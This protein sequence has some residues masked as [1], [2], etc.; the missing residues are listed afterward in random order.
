MASKDYFITN[1]KKI[2]IKKLKD[3]FSKVIIQDVRIDWKGYRIE[4]LNQKEFYKN[5][6]EA[7]N[8]LD[9]YLDFLLN[10]FETPENQKDIKTDE[11]LEVEQK[12]NIFDD[13]SKKT[14]K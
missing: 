8:D 11:Q 9:K 3:L 13:L 4:W 14:K 2:A 7:Q 1:S 6:V 5:S 12:A 10:K